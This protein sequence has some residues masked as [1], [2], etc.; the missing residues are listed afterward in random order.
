MLAC[1][2]ARQDA[3]LLINFKLKNFKNKNLWE[4]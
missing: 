1:L 2:P 4:N 3:K